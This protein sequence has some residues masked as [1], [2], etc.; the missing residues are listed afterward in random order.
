M[1]AARSGPIRSEQ[2]PIA[3]GAHHAKIMTQ[4]LNEEMCKASEDGSE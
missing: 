1:R 3:T 4:L 2:R